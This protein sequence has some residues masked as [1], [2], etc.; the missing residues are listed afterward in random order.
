MKRTLSSIF[1]LLSLILVVPAFGQAKVKAKDSVPQRIDRYGFRIGVD[2]YRLGMGIWDK[3][4]KGLEITA[5]YR[6]T[7]TYYA[8]SELG[9]EEKTT[10]DDRL[11]FT[12]KGQYLKLGFDYN[13]YDNWLSMDNMMYIGMRYGVSRFSNTVNSYKIYYPYPYFGENNQIQGGESFSNVQAHWLEVVAGIKAE[14]LPKIYMGFSARLNYLVYQQSP[15]G[16]ENLYIPGFNRTY[17]GKFGAGFTYTLSYLIPLYSK[18]GN[19][20]ITHA[21]SKKSK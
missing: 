2:A 17:G 6:L 15:D 7:R 14:V 21:N 18:R 16:F 20:I 5:D 12:A 19:H 13:L 4:Y 10:A 1:S 3:N 8:V 9:I 11:N